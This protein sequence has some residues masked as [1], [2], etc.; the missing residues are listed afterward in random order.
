MKSA[1]IGPHLI[2]HQFV[3]PVSVEQ[4]RN[5]RP[6]YKTAQ[7]PQFLASG[8][9]PNNAHMIPDLLGFCCDK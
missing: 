1:W 4:L 2:P 8:A 3:E 9:R 6:S 7:K 5:T